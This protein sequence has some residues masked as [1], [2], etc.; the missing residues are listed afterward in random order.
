MSLDEE[1]V[2]FELEESVDSLLVFSVVSGVLNHPL[3]EG[4]VNVGLVPG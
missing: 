1:V 3:L 2:L 4:D